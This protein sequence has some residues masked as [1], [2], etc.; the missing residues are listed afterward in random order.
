MSGSGNVSSARIRTGGAM[1]GASSGRGAV[2]ASGPVKNSSAMSFAEMRR[3][4]N[5]AL[6]KRR[7]DLV[8]E[9]YK[10][11]EQRIEAEKVIA[12]V[13]RKF[14]SEGRRITP[15]DSRRSA[16]AQKK[17]DDID[18]KMNKIRYDLRQLERTELM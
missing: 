3:K 7:D 10:L 2:K 6:L 14:W 4:R 17:I 8:D 13:T 12:E 16:R 15:A 5:L 11:R 18:S 9:L 1:G